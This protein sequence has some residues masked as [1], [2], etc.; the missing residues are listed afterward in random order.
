MRDNYGRTL[1]SA[2]LMNFSRPNTSCMSSMETIG[3]VVFVISV[4]SK[5]M[6]TQDALR[7]VGLYFC[8][9]QIV[10]KERNVKCQLRC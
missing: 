9:K 3:K 1:F 2:S 8:L 7:A 6:F 10:E 5:S 4:F